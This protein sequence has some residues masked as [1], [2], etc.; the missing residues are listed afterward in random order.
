MRPS[1]N[2][3]QRR[4]C[5]FFGIGG[6]DDLDDGVL[7]VQSPCGR[8]LRKSPGEPQP[9]R[10]SPVEG[11]LDLGQHLARRLQNWALAKLAP[12]R[13]LNERVQERR[14]V[15]V[16]LLLGAAWTES[17]GPPVG[18]DQDVGI[19]VAGG[20][21]LRHEP[22]AGFHSRSPKY[23]DSEGREKSV[24]G[25]IRSLLGSTSGMPDGRYPS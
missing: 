24:S 11:S 12:D 16:I 13:V 22:E 9:L 25:R 14:D 17:N 15:R 19:A 21:E 2:G 10:L 20:T 5:G 18:I 7:C 6:F 23:P 8:Y 1:F 4:L 3:S